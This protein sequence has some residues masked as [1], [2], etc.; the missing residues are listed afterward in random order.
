MF[1]ELMKSSHLLDLP[2]IGMFL[3]IGV[4]VGTLIWVL[5]KSQGERYASMSQLPLSHDSEEANP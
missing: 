1:S 4:F 3:F 5:R 2:L